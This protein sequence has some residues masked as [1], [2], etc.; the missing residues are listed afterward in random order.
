MIVLQSSTSI[1]RAL[2]GLQLL[3]NYLATPN[4]RIHPNIRNSP[5][6]L[7]TN[8]NLF[9]SKTIC[10]LNQEWFTHD[11][12]KG[13]GGNPIHRTTFCQRCRRQSKLSESTECYS[14]KCSTRHIKQPEDVIFWQVHGVDDLL[15]VYSSSA[16]RCAP[17]ITS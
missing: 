2:H 11:L 5:V 13:P 9:R 1:S 10:R 14:T 7:V 12:F 3:S 17:T 6:N 4:Y 8:N 16:T 15:E